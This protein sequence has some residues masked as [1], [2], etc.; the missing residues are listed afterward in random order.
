[1]TDTLIFGVDN[2]LHDEAWASAKYGIQFIDSDGERK[3]VLESARETHGPA[4]V[5]VRLVDEN[6]RPLPNYA[7]AF[8]WNGGQYSLESEEAKAAWVTRPAPRATIQF[9]DGGGVT[10]FGLGTGSY[11]YDL[12]V[13]GPHAI[14]ILDG[15]ASDVAARVGMLAGTDHHG[16][17]EFN[18]KLMT[19]M[20]SVP[21]VNQAIREAAWKD[22][23]IPLN[24]GA[25]FQRYANEKN[26]G[27][28][29]G[30]EKDIRLNGKT[31][32]TQ[33]FAGGIVMAEVG[34]WDKVSHIKW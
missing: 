24:P 17:L 32:R 25:A 10:G 11:I 26:L 14:C 31:Y 8:C 5:I 1:M 19:V 15:V 3:H 4:S 28:P 23:G 6:N 16:V 9:T 20:R 2:A 34:Q 30:D 27:I 13:G 33:K 29:F 12:N 7:V 18:F 21:D 22:M